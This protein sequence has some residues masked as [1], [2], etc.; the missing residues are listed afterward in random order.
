MIYSLSTTTVLALSALSGLGIS[1]NAFSPE[2]LKIAVKAHS[3]RTPLKD[4]AS[5]TSLQSKSVKNLR[6]SEESL[7]D[8]L[9]FLKPKPKQNKSK[10]MTFSAYEDEGCTQRVYQYGILLDNCVSEVHTSGEHRSWRV[11]LVKNRRAR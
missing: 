8:Y 7:S 3:Q 5:Y 9:P 1:V 11:Y 6:T 2:E 10:F 4:F